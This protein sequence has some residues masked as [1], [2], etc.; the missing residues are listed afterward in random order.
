MKKTYISNAGKDLEYQIRIKSESG[1]LDLKSFQLKKIPFN[2]MFEFQINSILKIDLSNNNFDTFPEDLIRFKNLRE[3]TIDSN[4]IKLIPDSL[5][6]LKKLKH[7]SIAHNNIEHISDQIVE[8]KDLESL[9]LSYNRLKKIPSNLYQIKLKTNK[10]SPQGLLLHGN[11]FEVPAE[12]F[13]QEPSEIL[14]FLGYSKKKEFLNEIKLIL[15]GEGNA[16]K[17]SLVNSFKNIPFDDELK[18][19]PGIEISNYFTKLHGRRFKI[20]IWDFGGQEIYHSMHQ[21]FLTKRS[22]YILVWNGRENDVNN[23]IEDWI[24]LIKS[25]GGDSPIIFVT[26]KIDDSNYSVDKKYL[27]D[28]YNIIDFIRTSSKTGEGIDDLRLVINKSLES[29]NHLSEKLP[30]MWIN[31]K[32]S[33]ES[34]NQTYITLDAYYSICKSNNIFNKGEQNSLLKLLHELGVCINFGDRDDFLS[35]NV[36][37]PEWVTNG[38]YSI[39]NS[40][41]IVD[42]NGV[43]NISHLKLILNEEIYPKHIQP[44]FIEIMKI[45]ELC[46]IYESSPKY[47]N[48]IIPDL[49]PKDE[50]YFNFNFDS[51]IKFQYSYLYKP[52]SILPRLLV[53]LNNLPD[54]KLFWRKGAIFDTNNTKILVKADTSDRIIEFYVKS[55]NAQSKSDIIKYIN[56]QFSLIHKSIPNLDFKLFVSIPNHYSILVNLNHIKDM[57]RKGLMVYYPEGFTKPILIEDILLNIDVNLE[58]IQPNYMASEDKDYLMYRYAELSEIVLIQDKKKKLLDVEIETDINNL[59]LYSYIISFLIFIIPYGFACYLFWD[60]LEP[61]TYLLGIVSTLYIL[62]LKNRWSRKL[63]LSSF[64]RFIVVDKKINLHFEKIKKKRTERKYIITELDIIGLKKK[65]DKILQIKDALERLARD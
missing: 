24:K 18:M 56:E 36:L 40:K 54:R 16:G 10:T 4:Y 38:I 46:Y 55:D 43:F 13:N 28:K 63:L 34:L 35:T 45:F 47:T 2:L 32:N 64:L 30:L 39:L 3:L 23:K 42:N 62:I 14:S 51:C 29:L 27:K 41:I 25:F 7:I 19:T 8:L 57:Y 20:N 15:L 53:K 59:K 37:D 65:K 31:V 11:N 33:V 48:Y 61:I 5:S 44:L 12:I 17:T 6:E 9:N 22:I 49:L 26:S 1:F 21:F 58:R 52:K 50:P 60:K